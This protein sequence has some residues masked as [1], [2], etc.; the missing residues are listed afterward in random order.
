MDNGRWVEESGRSAV[1]KTAHPQPGV[2][3][4][5]LVMRSLWF[6]K[7]GGGKAAD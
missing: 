7:G 1:T 2:A 4:L 6:G 3:G 5:V